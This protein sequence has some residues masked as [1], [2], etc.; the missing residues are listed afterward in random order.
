MT[1]DSAEGGGTRMQTG[2]PTLE[3]IEQRVWQLTDPVERCRAYRELFGT[4]AR[5]AG[6]W[7]PE[8]EASHRAHC[9]ES[10]PKP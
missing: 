7:T 10:Q 4:F 1:F 9:P 8:R 6:G 3:A 2:S 5:P